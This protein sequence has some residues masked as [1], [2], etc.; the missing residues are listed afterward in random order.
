MIF[1]Y[2]LQ[3]LYSVYERLKYCVFS[4]QFKM[5]AFFSLKIVHQYGGGLTLFRVF[6]T[7]TQESLEFI[8][9]EW[10]LLSG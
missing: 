10:I 2:D 5:D 1:T 3:H 8:P 9:N 4:L 7:H 6:N